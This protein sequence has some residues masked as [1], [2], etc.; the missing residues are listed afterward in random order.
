MGAIEFF[1]TNTL[2]LFMAN[3]PRATVSYLNTHLEQAKRS[4]TMSLRANLR[5]SVHKFVKNL[6]GNILKSTGKNC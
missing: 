1:M 6:V 3:T 5:T 2:A 4:N